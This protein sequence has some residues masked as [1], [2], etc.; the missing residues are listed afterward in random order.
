M[1][2]FASELGMATAAHPRLFSVWVL[3]QAVM[4]LMA[5]LLLYRR[6]AE[7]TRRRGISIAIGLFVACMGINYI[8][9]A[10]FPLPDLRHSGFGIAFLTLL[11]PWLLAWAFWN[12]P[13]ARNACYWQMVATPVLILLVFLQPGVVDFV[14]ATNMGLFQRI[15]AGTFYTWLILT[16]VWLD[17]LSANAPVLVRSAFSDTLL[18][19]ES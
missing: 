6:V 5:G 9:V 4:F 12:T 2:Q 18:G 15:G 10:V 14:D 1:R 11:V 8:F 17:R 19:E 16:G 3:I 13:R 7:L